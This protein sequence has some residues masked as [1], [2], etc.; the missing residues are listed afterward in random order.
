MNLQP[1]AKET[2]YGKYLDRLSRVYVSCS[3]LHPGGRITG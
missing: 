3:D 2:R 1:R